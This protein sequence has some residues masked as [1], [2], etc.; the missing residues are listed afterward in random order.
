MGL[1]GKKKIR[2]SEFGASLAL[3]LITWWKDQGKTIFDAA[4]EKTSAQATKNKGAEEALVLGMFAVTWACEN[5]LEGAELAPKVLDAF[6]RSLYGLLLED[7]TFR[8]TKLTPN[9]TL[10]AS[11]AAGEFESRL[12]RPRYEEYRNA[13]SSQNPVL[14]LGR[15]AARA[16]GSSQADPIEVLRFANVVSAALQ[17][18]KEIVAGLYKDYRLVR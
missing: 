1:F 7:G 18:M 16:L 10:D 8:P 3:L 4:I 6:H 5:S 11:V 13:L 9:V 15:V 14:G 2:V 12:V 17:V